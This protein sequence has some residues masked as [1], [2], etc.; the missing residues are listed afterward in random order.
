MY[1]A[2]LYIIWYNPVIDTGYNETLLL[3]S[4]SSCIIVGSWLTQK[5]VS[6]WSPDK[7]DRWQD[8]PYFKQ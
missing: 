5:G 1:R 6:T 4:Q 2:Y 8:I 7:F 3:Y